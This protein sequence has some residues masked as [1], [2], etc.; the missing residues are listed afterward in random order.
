MTLDHNASLRQA[1]PTVARLIDAEPGASASFTK[2]DGSPG[3]VDRYEEWIRRST[4]QACD[5]TA[6]S[7]C[8]TPHHRRHRLRRRTPGPPAARPGRRRAL[9]RPRP[10]EDIAEV[11]MVLR[12]TAHPPLR[13]LSPQTV[14]LLELVQDDRATLPSL[15]EHPLQRVHFVA[16]RSEDV[17]GG[18]A[19]TLPNTAV[20]N[21]ARRPG[22]VS[23]EQDQIF[24]IV[25]PPNCGGIALRRRIPGAD[26]QATRCPPAGHT[27]ASEPDRPLPLP[28]N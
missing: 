12:H 17:R 14:D 7:S 23:F 16:Q 5:R 24:T 4:C 13:R 22:I 8:A 1:D 2:L 18:F 21:V 15:R 11:L 9:P 19:A 26:R 10:R 25:A 20:W 6:A 3:R 28:T 27:I